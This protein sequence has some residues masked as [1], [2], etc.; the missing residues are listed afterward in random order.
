MILGIAYYMA[1]A[2]KEPLQAILAFF[3][4]VLMVIIATYLLFVAGSVAF[5]KVLQKNKKYYYK[6]NHFISVS[7][8]AY[9]MK[10]N[11]AGLASIFILSTMV[12]V[13]LSST[14]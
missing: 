11:G 6:T 9:R 2:I 5:C 10:R 8:M 14:V 4:A 12:L 7:Q 3:V 1:V 13:T